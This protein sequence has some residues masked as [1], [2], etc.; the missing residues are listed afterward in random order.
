[1]FHTD[2]IC[3]N[4]DSAMSHILKTASALVEVLIM[5]LNEG[6]ALAWK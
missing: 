3:D 2:K 5:F 4:Q 1:M 6:T